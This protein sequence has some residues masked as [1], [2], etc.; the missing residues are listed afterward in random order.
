MSQFKS[1]ERLSFILS[2]V[3]DHHYPSK[4]AIMAYLEGKHLYPTE[5]TFQRDLQTLRDMCFIILK[6][7]RTHNGYYIDQDSMPDFDNWM[8]VFELFNTARIINDTLIKSSANIE[9]IDFDR[10][11]M[12]MDPEI[13]KGL[14]QAV[15]DRNVIQFSHHSFWKVESRPMVVQPHLLKQYQNRWYLYGCF[16]NGDFRSFGIDRITDLE[17]LS[18]S[19]KSKMKRPKEMFDKI[20]GLVYEAEKV[21]EV[22]LSYD[23]FQGNYIKTQ[24]I[25]SSQKIL[26]DDKNELKISIRVI[27]NYEL[28]EQIMKQGERVKVLEP[29]WLREVVKERLKKAIEQY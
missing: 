26:V 12:R 27:P 9:Y 15:I 13:L 3:N 14:L 17:V 16:E 24:P 6:Y 11:T 18:E 2:Y 4:D 8:H 7:N 5:R 10:T 23:P 21:E 19:F 20:I 22:I 1:V 28:E 25:H 29:E